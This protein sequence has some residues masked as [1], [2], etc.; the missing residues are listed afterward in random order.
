MPA[1]DVTSDPRYLVEKTSLQSSFSS[2]EE[3]QEREASNLI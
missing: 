3:A 2:G 1:M